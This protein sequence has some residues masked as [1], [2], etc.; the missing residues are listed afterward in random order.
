MRVLLVGGGGREHALSWKLAQSP[1]L[2]ALYVAPGNPGMVEVAHCVA[3]ASDAVNELAA[4]AERER[5]D[6][7]IVGPEVPLALGVVDRFAER[8]LAAF[9][10]TRA[11]AELESSKV[12]AKRLFAR[13]G[14]PTAR[15]DTFAEPTRARAFVRELGGQAVVK[16]DGLAA[17]KGAVVCRDV[18]AADQA[19]ADMLERRVFGDA[20]AR[21]VIEE[22][23][24]GE[25]L[26]F[27]A[28]TDGEAICPLAAAQDHKTVFDDDQGANTGGMG[29]YS[30]PPVLD[31][32]LA[33]RIV[34]TVIRPSVRAMAAEGR[35]YRGV[36]YAGLM[37]TADGPK[38]LEYNVRFGDPECQPLMLR[39][40]GDLLPLCR[41]VAEGKGLPDAVEW[42]PEAAVC[43]VLASGGY[44]GAYTTGHPITGTEAAAGHSGV[45]VFH[46]GTA[47][48]DG[49]LVTAG[50]RVLGVTALGADIPAA[51]ARAY[52]AVGEIRFEGM[53][54]RRDIGRR[55]LIRRGSQP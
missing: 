32:G 46:A 45:T 6:L 25:E 10:P 55:A 24:A 43:V 49:R 44:P 18:A 9:G 8:G 31:G 21:I 35:P 28:L 12:F 2:D 17:G 19:I 39:L 5:I 7:T 47:R 29:A 41:A 51:I 48:R 1:V 36:L 30:P 40:A 16:A 11:A 38:L 23:L 15:F 14:I 53:H 37:L 4:F 33:A 34:D 3:I 52:A 42:R 27:F 13:Y 20:G 26:S 54:F 22:L 50:G